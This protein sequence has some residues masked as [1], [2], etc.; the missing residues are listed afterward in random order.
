MS[1]SNRESL[2]FPEQFS[3]R[4][5]KCFAK[6]HWRH[7]ER[8]QQRFLIIK[9]LGTPCQIARKKALVIVRSFS[10]AIEPS[11]KPEDSRP[12]LLDRYSFYHYSG[13]TAGNFD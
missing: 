12:H 3:T 11:D 5:R 4:G 2:P 7:R 10:V 6:Y 13:L 9:S 8:S 1:I